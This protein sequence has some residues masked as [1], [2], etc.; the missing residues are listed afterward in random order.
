MSKDFAGWATVTGLLISLLLLGV[1]FGMW[2]DAPTPADSAVGKALLTFGAC[3]A[4]ITVVLLAIAVSTA[5]KS[6]SAAN[7]GRSDRE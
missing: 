1:G 4:I 2:H 7:P 3:A 6:V 5:P